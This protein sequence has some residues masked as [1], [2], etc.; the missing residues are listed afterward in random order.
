MVAAPWTMQCVSSDCALVMV[1]LFLIN[2]EQG[3]NIFKTVK[4]RRLVEEE[5]VF[6]IKVIGAYLRIQQ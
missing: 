1:F 6:H 2:T 5:K 4:S 3:T